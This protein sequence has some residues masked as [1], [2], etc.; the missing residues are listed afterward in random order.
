MGGKI[1]LKE[2]KG[3]LP[4]FQSQKSGSALDGRL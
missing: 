2:A 3:V 1:Q 4:T